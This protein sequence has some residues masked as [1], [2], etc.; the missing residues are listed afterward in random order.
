MSFSWVFFNVAEPKQSALNMVVVAAAVSS[1]IVAAF[2]LTAALKWRCRK[3]KDQCFCTKPGDH[4]KWSYLSKWSLLSEAGKQV[5]VVFSKNNTPGANAAL[6]RPLLPSMY[7]VTM[8]GSIPD[9]V[10]KIEAKTLI[11]KFPQQMRWFGERGHGRKFE[12]FHQPS[13]PSG[14]KGLKRNVKS[15]WTGPAPSS[16]GGGSGPVIKN[17]VHALHWSPFAAPSL[18]GYRGLPIMHTCKSLSW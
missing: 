16:S 3:T 14:V 2:G 18:S 6:T 10:H 4:S 17:S 1:V 5:N 7:I 15:R 8:V 13:R 11:K 9:C 12:F